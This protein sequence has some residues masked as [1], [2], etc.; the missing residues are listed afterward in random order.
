MNLNSIIDL[1]THIPWI[2]ILIKKIWK[3]LLYSINIFVRE[4]RHLER[5]LFLAKV[6]TTCNGYS[7][8]TKSLALS[9]MNLKRT[10]SN[11]HFKWKPSLDC[12]HSRLLCIMMYI[13]VALICCGCSAAIIF[14]KIIGVSLEAI[15]QFEFFVF[16]YNCRRKKYKLTVFGM[17][18]QFMWGSEFLNY[19]WGLCLVP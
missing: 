19:K 1:K 8:Y 16:G 5:W 3:F 11:I 9:I 10:K 18:I 6:P 2:D 14:Y 4:S 15:V 17:H 7:S 13:F 12:Q